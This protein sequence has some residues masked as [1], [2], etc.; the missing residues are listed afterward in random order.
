VEV[1]GRAGLIEDGIQV[2]AAMTG[3]CAARAA[4]LA[5]LGRHADALAALEIDEMSPTGLNLLFYRAALDP[6]RSDPR[7]VRFVERLG[8]KDAHARAQ[9]WRAANPPEKVEVKK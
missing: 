8:L 9:A 3:N 4:A 6:V 5:T 2:S 7:F 1:F